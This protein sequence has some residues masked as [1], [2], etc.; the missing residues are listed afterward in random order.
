LTLKKLQFCNDLSFFDEST[1]IVTS[2]VNFTN[3]LRAAFAL[4]DPKSAKGTV[5][6]SVFFVLLGSARVKAA[7]KHW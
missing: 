7:Q 6:L 4:A 2:G 1:C 3:V 5:K